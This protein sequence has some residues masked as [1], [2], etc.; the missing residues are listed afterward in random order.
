M[1]KKL[2]EW[3]KL[4]RST[5]KSNPSM[6]I[7]EVSQEASR[8]YN[9]GKEAVSNVSNAIVKKTKKKR[10]GGKNTRRNKKK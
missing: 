6:S 10:K 3:Q 4:I 1:V 5:S 7:A 8:V 2:S 9:K